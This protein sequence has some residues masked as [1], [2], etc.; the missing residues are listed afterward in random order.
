MGIALDCIFSQYTVEAVSRRL[1]GDYYAHKPI[2]HCREV[3]VLCD[4][5]WR[6]KLIVR[7]LVV[8]PRLCNCPGVEERSAFVSY[9][10]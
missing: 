8:C 1:R 7:L 6:C 4:M 2:K 10:N 9:G 3:D 5:Y